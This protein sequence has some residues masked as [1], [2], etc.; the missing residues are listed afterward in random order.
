MWIIVD[1]DSWTSACRS[2][3]TG[4]SSQLVCVVKRQFTG[5]F[6]MRSLFE[7]SVTLAVEHSLQCAATVS[8]VVVWK[9]RLGGTQFASQVYNLQLTACR[10]LDYGLLLTGG[11]SVE[12]NAG[13]W[14]QGQ[15]SA[16]SCAV[17]HRP[18]LSAL[19]IWK[20]VAPTISRSSKFSWEQVRTSTSRRCQWLATGIGTDDWPQTSLEYALGQCAA[21]A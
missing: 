16:F 21:F 8:R 11:A 14:L 9:L 1:G 15:W 6:T 17:C 4:E 3:F 2:R 5:M 10:L 13:R 20:F 12:L 18:H 7:Q 19:G